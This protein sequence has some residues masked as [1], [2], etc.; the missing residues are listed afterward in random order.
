MARTSPE[1]VG[2]P[3][4]RDQTRRT[5]VRAHAS[6]RR[7][8]GR[9]PPRG[10]SRLACRSRLLFALYLSFF[11]RILSFLTDRMMTVAPPPQTAGATAR[12]G[13]KAEHRSARLVHR[14]A[15]HAAREVGDA[16]R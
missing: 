2:G 14:W 8:G 11:V 16:D 1:T 15:I 4:P 9:L 5:R 6:R 12:E 7:I 3:P 13:P 10:R